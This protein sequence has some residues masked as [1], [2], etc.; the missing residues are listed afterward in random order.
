MLKKVNWQI[1]R[2]MLYDNGGSKNNNVSGSD[3]HDV[4]S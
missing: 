1:E 4:Y 2:D 3:N